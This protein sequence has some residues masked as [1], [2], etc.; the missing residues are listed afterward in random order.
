[1]GLEEV[2]Q[3][4]LAG[5]ERE[6]TR[7]IEDGN[8][9]AARIRKDA[10]KTIEA[11]RVSRA[12]DTQRICHQLERRELAQA[13]FDAKKRTLDKKKEMAERAFAQARDALKHQPDAARAAILRKLFARARR[14][15]T[16]GWVYVNS[17]DKKLM[18][19]L[20]GKIPLKEKPLLGGLV[21]ET[22]D[23]SISVDY[24]Y[25]HFLGQIQENSMQELNST[26]FG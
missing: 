4:I 26:L 17:R 9:E 6:A 2:K 24:S 15:I 21:A 20:A 11:Y 1:M 14:D 18:K 25:E 8:T 22:P 3:D 5:A 7:V 12:E 10:E 23:G 13:E 19:A 16:I